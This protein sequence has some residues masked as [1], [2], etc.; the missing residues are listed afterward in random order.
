M[1]LF[2]NRNVLDIC[3]KISTYFQDLPRT[4]VDKD[5]EIFVLDKKAFALPV[6]KK[7]IPIIVS[8]M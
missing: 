3:Q 4:I 7:K 1:V 5:L 2:L 8:N 6:K